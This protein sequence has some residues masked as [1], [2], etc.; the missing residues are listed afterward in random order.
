MNVNHRLC[1]IRWAIQICQYLSRTVVTSFYD[2]PNMTVKSWRS[3]DTFSMPSID[4]L[5]KFL[6]Y[7]KVRKF[8]LLST[9]LVASE[10]SRWIGHSLLI[11]GTGLRV[12][13]WFRQFRTIQDNLLN[14]S[15]TISQLP[16]EKIG[17]FLT[18]IDIINKGC[19][20]TGVIFY[21][22]LRQI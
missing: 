21:S 14:F 7:E 19:I 1:S 18:T 3:P 13:Q 11:R 10:G 20:G 17:N 12:R 2:T 6:I 4:R 15:T 9:H 8:I 22:T 16:R 5:S